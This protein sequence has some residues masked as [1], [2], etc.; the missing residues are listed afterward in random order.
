MAELGA[1]CE[2]VDLEVV[3]SDVREAPALYVDFVFRECNLIIPE[4]VMRATQNHELARE[5]GDIAPQAPEQ[6][7]LGAAWTFTRRT[8]YSG[9]A[10]TRCQDVFGYQ[11]MRVI[12]TLLGLKSDWLTE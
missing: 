10:Y 2:A 6:T 11:R 1:L 9:W 4:L 3:A 8:E 5:L 12:G 7:E